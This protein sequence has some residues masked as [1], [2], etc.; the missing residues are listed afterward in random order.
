MLG[1]DSLSS[2]MKPH[3][4]YIG[5]ILVSVCGTYSHLAT[6]ACDGI[7]K[8]NPPELSQRPLLLDQWTRAAS[9]HQLSS[10]STVDSLV[11]N[12]NQACCAWS[13]GRTAVSGLERS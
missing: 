5:L 10:M 8:H 13:S 1:I 4:Y 9:I 12:G 3:Y 7:C 2:R 6:H 11:P